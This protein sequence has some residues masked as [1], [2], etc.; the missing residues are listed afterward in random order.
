MLI[1]NIF[2]QYLSFFLVL[3]YNYLTC[4]ASDEKLQVKMGSA[5]TQPLSLYR[6]TPLT[7]SLALKKI[8]V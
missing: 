1:D 3:L 4:L 5:L 6:C 7:V 8:R 2:N